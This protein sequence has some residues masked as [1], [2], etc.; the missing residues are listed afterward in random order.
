MYRVYVHV[1]TDHTSLQYVFCQ[2]DLNIFQR[3]WL[4]LLK[5]YEM[6]VHYHPNEEN[7]VEN[8]LSRLSIGSV[9]HIDDD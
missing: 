9:A 4:E 5:D 2:K 1:F 7:M 8:A 3:S 6:S